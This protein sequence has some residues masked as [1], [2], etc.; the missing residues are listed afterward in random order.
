[1]LFAGW[2]VDGSSE[3]LFF[4]FLVV[5][6]CSCFCHWCFAIDSPSFSWKYLAIFFSSLRVLMEYHLLDKSTSFLHVYRNK[7]TRCGL[8]SAGCFWCPHQLFLRSLRA[9]KRGK[10]VGNC[11]LGVVITWI[12]MKASSLELIAGFS[13]VR[14]VCRHPSSWGTLQD[15]IFFLE[16]NCLSFSS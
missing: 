8:D 9:E 6:L 13:K 10:K 3:H 2:I 7:R 4:F 14:A 1:M 12:R 5:T 11:C 15:P 16:L